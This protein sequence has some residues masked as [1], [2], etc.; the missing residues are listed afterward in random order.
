MAEP[1][2][3]DHDY[4]FS[5]VISESVFGDVYAEPSQWQELGDSNLFQ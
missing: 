4:S 2:H 5:E 1:L 3:V